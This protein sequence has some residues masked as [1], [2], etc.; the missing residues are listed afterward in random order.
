MLNL[1]LTEQLAKN[2]WPIES[3]MICMSKLLAALPGLYL[4]LYQSA[5]WLNL[6]YY[7]ADAQ[8]S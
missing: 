1:P 3:T 7:E 2:K 8:N 5:A 4:L 6:L